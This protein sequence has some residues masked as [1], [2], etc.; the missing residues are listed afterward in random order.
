MFLFIL[1][2]MHW[3]GQFTTYKGNKM[4]SVKILAFAEI[5]TVFVFAIHE[6]ILIQ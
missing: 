2:D 1:F 3:C 4:L 6:F 5:S